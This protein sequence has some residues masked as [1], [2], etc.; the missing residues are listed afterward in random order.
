MDKKDLPKKFLK[1]KKYFRYF[2]KFVEVKK[3]SKK[4][5]CLSFI[6]NYSK[7]DKFVIGVNNYQ[8][9]KENLELIKLKT[10]KI[11]THLQVKSQRLINPKFW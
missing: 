10:I 7:I 8:Q 11:P 3:I 6:R 2:D 5:A 4:Y 9:I 1:W